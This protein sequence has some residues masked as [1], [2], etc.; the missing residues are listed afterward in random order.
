MHSF[1]IREWIGVVGALLLLFASIPSSLYA[2]TRAAVEG[3]VTTSDGDPLPGVQIVDPA[4]QRGTVS[5]ANGT[6]RLTKLPPGPHTLEFRFVGYQTAI[7]DITLAVGETTTLNVS[8]KTRVLQSEGV[9]VTG[10]PR[11][12]R[13]LRAPQDV[14]VMGPAQLQAQRSAA[15]GDMLRE[16]VAGVSSIQTGSQAGKPVLRGLSGTRVLLLKDGIGQEFYQF[17]VRHFPTTNASEAERIEVV[18]GASSILYG[19]DALGGAINVITKPAP[20]T[21]QESLDVGGTASTQYYTNNNERAGSVDLYAAQGDLGWRVGIERRIGDN[22][23]TPDEPT[24]SETGTGGTFGDPRY[25]GE[26]PFTNFEQ[27][28]TYAQMGMQGAFG[29]IQ[30]YGDYWQSAQNFLL[31]D[32]G[33]PGQTP[34]PARGLGQNLEHSNV[35]LK[36]NLV[37]NGTVVK[38]R[39]S[40]QRSVRQA[41]PGGVSVA[42]IRDNGGL[43][44]FDYPLDLKTDVYT[45]RVEVAHSAIGVISGTLGADIQHQ[46]ADTRGPAELQPSA[47]LWNVGVF[48]FEEADLDPITVT[49]GARLD[50]R[51]IDAVPNERTTDPDALEADYTTLSGS[52]GASYALGDGVA[53][54]TNLSSGFRAPT[55]FELYANGVHGGVAAF[56]VGNP[57][58]DP[59]RSY[60]GDLSFRVQRDRV[61]AEVTGYLNAINDYIYL[62]NTGDVNAGSGLPVYAAAQTD[63]LLSGIEAQVEVSARPW[64]QVGGSTAIVDGTGDGLGAQ[65]EDDGDLPLLPSNTFSGFVRWVPA[66]TGLITNP[67][68]EVSLK[69]ALEQDAAGRFEPFAQFDGGFGPPFGTAST[70]AYTVVDLK[71]KST[72]EGLGTPLTL[73]IGVRNLFDAAYRDFL[74]TYKGYA[75]SPGRDVRFTL[76]TRF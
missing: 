28:S 3:R 62:E 4:L 66:G 26:V 41:A 6:Y 72:F 75:L 74:D 22:F 31:P 29:T 15:L 44:G 60:S 49:A 38:P 58:L 57:A 37:L 54:A 20:T 56:Q 36:G 27:W 34:F 7:R 1:S 76:S 5:D 68:V 48:A 25:T 71:A 14:D 40:W 59:E 69:H 10:T 19:S 23:H 63:A 50:V 8:L 35:A 21:G 13:T 55:I 42:D 43:G 2:Q 65:A 51:T 32:G 16:N 18:R 52:L 64:L 70:E 17:G 24:F 61:T 47:R 46:D 33:T 9:T 67:S 12:R 45:G 11:A 30:L 73:T 39:L 53:I